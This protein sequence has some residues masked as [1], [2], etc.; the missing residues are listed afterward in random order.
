MIFTGHFHRKR[1]LL[2]NYTSKVEGIVSSH[3]RPETEF[4]IWM[5]Q[6]SLFDANDLQVLETNTTFLPIDIRR[7][8]HPKKTVYLNFSQ[9]WMLIITQNASNQQ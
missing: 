4:W 8:A 6:G 7:P 2:V 9:S 3:V 5:F 1:C